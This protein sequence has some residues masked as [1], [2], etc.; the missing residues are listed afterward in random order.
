M[1]RLPPELLA[2]VCSLSD[3][4]SL[5]KIRLVNTIC[6][7]IAA[8]YLFEGLCFSLIPRYLDKVT[9]VAFHPTLRFYVRTL[10]FD[11][12]ILD[13]KYADYKTWEAEID[14]R[15]HII[16]EEIW[17]KYPEAARW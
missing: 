4:R 15:E 13:E 12:D 16:A 11:L 7:R 2:Q 1:D 8:Q 6:A 17:P 10:Y 9:E 14:T 5:K 3:I